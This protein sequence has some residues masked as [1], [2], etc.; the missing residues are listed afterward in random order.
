MHNLANG[1]TTRK[2]ASAAERLSDRLRLAALAWPARR[3][4][5]RFGLRAATATTIAELIGYSTEAR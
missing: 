5:R 2:T 4:S 1:P 3:L